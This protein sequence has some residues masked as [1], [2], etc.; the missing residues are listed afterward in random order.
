LN[1]V[2]SA[3]P[4]AP[5]QAV[6]FTTTLAPTST[7]PTPTGSVSY[8]DGSIAPAN[9][10]N[11]ASLVNGQ[12]S[13]STSSL[14]TG[15]HFIIASYSGDSTYATGST[16]LP[17]VVLHGTTTVIA[18]S[19]SNS[20][21]GST[22]TFTATVS[23]GDGT[24]ATKVVFKDGNTV[25]ANVD[26]VNGQATYTTSTLSVGQHVISAVYRGEG[27]PNT[28]H[29]PAV[30]TVSQTVQGATTT[31]VVGSPS[32][33]V[34]GQ[35][36]TFTA[37]VSATLPGA[38]VPVGTVTFTE[39][40]TVLASGVALDGTGHASFSTS[41]LTLANHT[42]TATYTSSGNWLNSGSSTTEAVGKA[43]SITNLVSSLNPA[44][45][46][47]SVLFV[48][49][50]TANA[51]GAGTLTGTVTFMD[52]NK[53]LGTS[54]L[55]ASGLATFTTSSLKLGNHNITAVYN[56]DS[57]F[58]TSSSAILNQVIKNQVHSSLKEL[59]LKLLAYLFSL[60]PNS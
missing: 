57:H 1:N 52:G 27:G 49:M 44:G 15:T 16:M 12:A 8:Y 42:I 36:V 47:K 25:L 54:T 41:A 4:I 11:T 28:T 43:S 24:P 5:G 22:V 45:K 33:S 56:G 2:A 10:L 6:T 34:F 13:F 19:N 14:T 38:G 9:L 29:I 21:F 48:V 32:S 26:L 39:G 51:P 17:E 55:N 40:A 37:T 7:G 59:S 46:Y 31:V 20:L 18:S 3:G 58:T 50:V 35:L 23:A 60:F 30:A 53:V